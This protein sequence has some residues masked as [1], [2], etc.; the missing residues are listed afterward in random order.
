MAIKNNHFNT[1]V[2]TIFHKPVCA[3]I[4][5]LRITCLKMTVNGEYKIG[6]K[7]NTTKATPT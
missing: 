5:K 3:S 4:T 1:T 7:L 2:L 6:S